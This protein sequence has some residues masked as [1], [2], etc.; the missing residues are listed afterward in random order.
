VH[1]LERHF[2][3]RE[4][5]RRRDDILPHRFMNEEIPSGP[6]KGLRTTPADLQAMLDDYYDLRGWDRDGVPRKE[7][8]VKLRLG[9]LL[10]SHRCSP[11]AATKLSFE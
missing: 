9:D 7:T 8:L 5:L 6:S 1:T 2:N 11:A 4:G 3:C 10:T